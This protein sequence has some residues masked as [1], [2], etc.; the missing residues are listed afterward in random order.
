V[1]WVKYQALQA[2]NAELKREVEFSGKIS[3]F[4]VAKQR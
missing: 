2:E 4:L 1:E 3:A